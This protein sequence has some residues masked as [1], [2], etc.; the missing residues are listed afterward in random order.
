MEYLLLIIGVVAGI[1]A[2]VLLGYLAKSLWRFGQYLKIKAPAIWYIYKVFWVLLLLVILIITFASAV[3][4]YNQEKRRKAEKVFL[5]SN[6]TLINTAASDFVDLIYRN[7]D[8]YIDDHLEHLEKCIPSYIKLKQIDVNDFYFD[9]GYT[10]VDRANKL[11]E[12]ITPWNN[13]SDEERLRITL[14]ELDCDKKLG[15]LTP[16]EYNLRNKHYLTK[17]KVISRSQVE[18]VIQELKDKGLSD[19]SIMK[20]L[21]AN[22]NF[23]GTLNYMITGYDISGSP[24]PVYVV[25]REFGLDTDSD[26]PRINKAMRDKRLKDMNESAENL[27]LSI[28]ALGATPRP[29]YSSARPTPAPEVIIDNPYV[30]PT[31]ES[32]ILEHDSE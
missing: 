15:K 2:L 14:K 17:P 23:K 19:K 29:D 3:N 6:S 16:E 31:P 13:L 10:V 5:E 22:E 7:D 30:V 20:E 24:N 8:I 1:L 11:R 12:D 32:D 9:A 26:I 18:K 27:R 28:D 25:G 21:L 4:Y